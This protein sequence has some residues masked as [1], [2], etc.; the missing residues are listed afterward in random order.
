MAIDQNN[1]ILWNSNTAVWSNNPYV[2][3]DI[4]IVEDAEKGIPSGGI[5]VEDFLDVPPQQKEKRKRFIRLVMYL[6]GDKVYD[7]T[8]E[9]QED[10]RL[11][12]DDVE[13]VKKDMVRTLGVKFK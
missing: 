12:L 2:W 13:I 11:T 9:V 1:R 10:I 3:S 4:E 5:A 6:K 7:E 8:K